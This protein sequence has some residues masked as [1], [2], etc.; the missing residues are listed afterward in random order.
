MIWVALGNV[1]MLFTVLHWPREMQCQT[2]DIKRCYVRQ[3]EPPR[4]V[5]WPKRGVFMSGQGAL[6][7]QV[8]TLK[9]R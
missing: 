1:L 5:C 9:R 3:Y 4:L 7:W 6:A 2:C 8:Q